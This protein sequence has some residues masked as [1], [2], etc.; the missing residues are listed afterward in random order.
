MRVKATIEIEYDVDLGF[1]QFYFERFAK[2]G[3]LA[4]YV[5]KS[6]NST[7][8]DSLH[9]LRDDTFDPE[10]IITVEEVK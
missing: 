6:E 2:K 1:H 3:S 4:E 8:R 5:L 7:I 10:I 9:E